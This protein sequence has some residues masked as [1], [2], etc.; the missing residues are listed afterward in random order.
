MDWDTGDFQEN[1]W[2]R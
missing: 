1:R 2:D